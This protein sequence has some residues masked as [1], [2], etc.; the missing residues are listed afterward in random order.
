[1]SPTVA[2]LGTRYAD[3]SVEE[4]VLGPLGVQLRRGT[5][6]DAAAIVEVAGDADVIVTGSRPRF[7]AEVLG[8][9]RCRGIVR[10]GVGVETVDLDAARRLG[11]WVANVPDYGTEAVAQ[12]TLTL[13]LAAN[14][15]LIEAHRLVSDGGWGVTELAP[16]HLP[17][18]LIAGVIGF[19]RIG[20]RVAQ[21]LAAVGFA[22]VLA[23]DAAARPEGPG[24]EA[25]DLDDLLSESDVVTLHVPAAA[26]GAAL[27]DAARLA[28]MRPGSVLV[29]TARGVLVDAAAL[30]GALAEGR[31]RVAALDV[32]AT[33]PPD[34]G[35]Y[36]DVIDRLILSPHMAWYTEQTQRDLRRRT[37]QE[38]R[39]L[40]RGE[41]PRNPVARPETPA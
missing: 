20:R 25:R 13:V 4:E 10:A 6:A 39:R 17:S 32:F 34:L 28:R 40:L 9:L 23:H 37:A 22:R 15:R 8:R 27:L 30:A 19:G 38:A 36:A 7:D 33:E 3:L 41:P 24:V 16:L 18:T 35:V 11:V 29:N 2:V 26:D 14:R 5:G 1:M 21:L 31:P 12:H